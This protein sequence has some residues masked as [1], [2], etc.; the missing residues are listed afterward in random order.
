MFEGHIR[1]ETFL[2]LHSIKAFKMLNLVD[3]LEKLCLVEQNSGLH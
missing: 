3:N 1:F 2:I